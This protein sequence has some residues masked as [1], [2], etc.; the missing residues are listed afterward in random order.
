MLM[1]T[2]LLAGEFTPFES[3]IKGLSDTTVNFNKGDMII[4]PGTK[5][6]Y[7]Y[8]IEKGVAIFSILHE[9]GRSKNCNFRGAGTI[10]PLFYNYA[11]TLME[12]Y[13]E[14]KA[15]SDIRAIQLTRE[16]MK[17]LMTCNNQF[18][19]R[20]SDCYCKYTTMLQYDLSMQIFDSSLVKTSNFLFIYMKYMNPSR[21][22]LVALSQEEIGNTIGLSRSNTSRALNTLKNEG[23]ITISR[24]N[25]R[26]VDPDKLL[27]FCSDASFY[28]SDTIG[29]VQ[30]NI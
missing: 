18:A 27:S 6:P 23:V 13:M 9:S 14:V 17:Q 22:G 21:S 2:Y 24:G 12:Q 29:S 11:S 8:Y 25:I 7:C 15:F 30:D 26:I 20:M 5:R 3:V 19:I 1:P 4:S 28:F 10:F 16:Q